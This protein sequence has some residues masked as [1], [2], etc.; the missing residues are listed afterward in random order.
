M[1]GRT[2]YALE[3]ARLESLRRDGLLDVSEASEFSVSPLGR[4]LLRHVAMA[5]DAYLD[6]AAT[7]PPKT[8]GQAPRWDGSKSSENRH[9]RSIQASGSE[10]LCGTPIPDLGKRLGSGPVPVHS[11]SG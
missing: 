7:P 1:T 4:V 6:R 2:D 5:F 11:D 3:L 8:F 9:L 10:A